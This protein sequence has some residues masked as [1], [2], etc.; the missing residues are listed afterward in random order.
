MYNRIM[1]K[2]LQVFYLAQWLSSEKTVLV[3][4]IRY[5]SKLLY[6]KSHT[7]L[8]YILRLNNIDIDKRYMG[9]ITNLTTINIIL[10]SHKQKNCMSWGP[11][12]NKISGQC[13]VTDSV[14]NLV[15]SLD[16]LFTI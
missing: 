5:P 11:S 15:S 13:S 6:C 9:H 12:L 14:L 7:G 4:D 8:Q 3:L 1:F 16:S 10:W 2:I